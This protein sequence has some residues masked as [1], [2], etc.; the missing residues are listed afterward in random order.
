MVWQRQRTL[1]SFGD[2]GRRIL[3]YLSPDGVA[4]S[5]IVQDAQSQQS[6]PEF[7]FPIAVVTRFMW[8]ERGYGGIITS[9]WPVLEF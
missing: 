4:S 7:R 2:V 1:G 8:N 5:L 6:D 9:G 3:S